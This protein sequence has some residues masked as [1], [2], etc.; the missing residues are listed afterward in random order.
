MK[1]IVSFSGGK[2]STVLLL[3]MLEKNMP[4]DEILF[5]DTGKEFPAMYNHI[6]KVENYIGRKITTIKAKKSFDY[7]ISTETR[8]VNINKHKGLGWAS[9]NMR[10]CTGELKK[11]PLRL[12]LKK[13]KKNEIREYIGIAHDESIRA[14][15]NKEKR[16]LFYPLIDWKITEKMA[17]QYCYSKGFNWDGLY[18]KFARVSCYCC[19]LQK[20]SELET[21]YLEY[22]KLWEDMRKI[23]K[24]SYRQFRAD[25]SLSELEKKFEKKK[26]Q[27]KFDF[28]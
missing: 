28:T 27:I 13:Y 15:H 16:N 4:V 2:D 8:K 22:P 24:M 3:M 20:L 18:E 19:P 11:E 7:L 5:C 9:H 21:I 26:L 1:H 6:K 25:Y 10:W 17:L 23:D 14:T 12:Y